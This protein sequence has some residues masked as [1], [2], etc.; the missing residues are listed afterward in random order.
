MVIDLDTWNRW[1]KLKEQGENLTLRQ[2]LAD[3]LAFREAMARMAQDLAE[4]A[5]N[6]VEVNFEPVQ[7][8][9]KHYWELNAE[10][11][12]FVQRVAQFIELKQQLVNIERYLDV[13]VRLWLNQW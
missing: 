10:A 7:E 2:S 6:L 3:L 9:V 5:R 12:V 13:Q 11:E 1:V 8:D 4:I